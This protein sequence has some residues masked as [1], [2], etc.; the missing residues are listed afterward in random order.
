MGSVS[1]Y[2]GRMKISTVSPDGNIGIRLTMPLK[3]ELRFAPQTFPRYGEDQL[4]FQLTKLASMTWSAYQQGKLQA[5]R[6]AYGLSE[7]EFPDSDNFADDLQSRR[8]QRAL[9]QLELSGTSSGRSV[10]IH[11]QAMNQWSVR[12]GP[13]AIRELGEEK[14]LDEIN[15]AIDALLSDREMKTIL[16]KAE[17]FSLGL[18]KK[19]LDLMKE[20]QVGKDHQRG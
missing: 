2:L 20:L 8:Y 7:A 18:P 4:A 9:S 10:Q 5:V 17:Y 14:F 15:S 3:V 19:W 1:D 13:G 6:R 11:T 16:L 12:V